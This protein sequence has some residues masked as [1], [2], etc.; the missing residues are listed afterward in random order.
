MTY[1]NKRLWS[2]VSLRW[3]LHLCAATGQARERERRP[4]RLRLVDSIAR[5]AAI[6]HARPKSPH[7]RS[8]ASTAQGHARRGVV[9][10]CVVRVRALGSVLPRGAQ[11]LAQLGSLLPPIRVCSCMFVYV[12]FCDVRGRNPRLRLPPQL[13][14]HSCPACPSAEHGPRRCQGCEL[15]GQPLRPRIEDAVA[16]PSVLL[17]QA[18]ANSCVHRNAVSAPSTSGGA[19]ARSTG[20]HDD[21]Q[22]SERHEGRGPTQCRASRVQHGAHRSSAKR[23][24]Q[25]EHSMRPPEIPAASA[26]HAS[27]GGAA[28]M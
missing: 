23:R 2:G 5:G 17:R 7:I 18:L 15:P 28:G 21:A 22:D 26:A 19:H 10:G 12:C 1:R 8:R 14:A 3:H 9:V 4:E 16:P 25:T 13:S 24:P 6:R 20:E 11:A 27:S